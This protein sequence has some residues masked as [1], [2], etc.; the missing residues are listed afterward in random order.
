MA[1]PGS[2]Q[3]LALSVRFLSA[4]PLPATQLPP[5]GVH[6]PFPNGGQGFQEQGLFCWD[7]RVQGTS[8]CLALPL[9][10]MNRG[11]EE[12]GDPLWAQVA[13][14]WAARG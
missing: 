14:L 7:W 3:G 4:G 9:P 10:L 8:G 12:A 5:P 1:K 11:L 2:A 13:G 6:F